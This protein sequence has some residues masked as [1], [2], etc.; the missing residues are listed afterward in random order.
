MPHV[1]KLKGGGQLTAFCMADVLDEIGANMG[2][3]I[4]RFIEEWKAGVDEE[5]KTDAFER[6]E[7]EKCLEQLLDHN[8]SLLFD[9]KLEAETLDELLDADRL[10]RKQLREEVRTMRHMLDREL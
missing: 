2:D 9:L 4:R 7:A 1:I 10:N 5:R 6:I 3:E 8:H